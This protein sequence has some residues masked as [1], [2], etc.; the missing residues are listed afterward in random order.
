MW[1][2]I[3]LVLIVLV[4]STVHAK[5]T[6]KTFRGVV[7]WGTDDGSVGGDLSPVCLYKRRSTVENKI[8]TTCDYH[9][10]CE[11]VGLVDENDW[12]VSVYKIRKINTKIEPST[13]VIKDAAFWAAG[14]QAEIRSGILHF[15]ELYVLNFHSITRGKETVFVVDFKLEV[16]DDH[17]RKKLGKGRVSMVKR[18][19]EWHYFR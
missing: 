18:G 10:E 15:R 9:D 12:L 17:T 7:D 13:D 5:N 4:S 14:I 2:F 6:V 19:D 11:L 1:R 3:V 8:L 16:Y